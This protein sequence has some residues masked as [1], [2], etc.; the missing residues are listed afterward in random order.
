MSIN[1]AG[2]AYI[3]TM[4]CNLTGTSYIATPSNVAGSVHIDCTHSCAYQNKIDV[5]CVITTI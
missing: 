3:A 2:T 4:Y 1:I 5:A